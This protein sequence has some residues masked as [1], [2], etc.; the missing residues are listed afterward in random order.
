MIALNGGGTALF[1]GKMVHIAGK[2]AG[3]EDKGFHG[4]CLLHKICLYDT[5]APGLAAGHDTTKDRRA[6]TALRSSCGLYKEIGFYGRRLPK[7]GRLEKSPFWHLRSCHR[8]SLEEGLFSSFSRQ[9]S[10][11][12]KVEE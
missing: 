5:R 10:V 9:K 11:F 3:C 1:A 12:K 7:R 2:V 8:Q 6:P 4:R